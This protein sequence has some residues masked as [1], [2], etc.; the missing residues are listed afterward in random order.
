MS[1]QNSLQ[2]AKEHL[3]VL[4]DNIK[5]K[6]ESNQEKYFDYI[7]AYEQIANEKQLDQQ[8]VL[9]DNSTHL[10]TVT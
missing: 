5:E 2:Q 9:S 10:T 7:E 3:G 8:M 4:E 1:Y 6:L